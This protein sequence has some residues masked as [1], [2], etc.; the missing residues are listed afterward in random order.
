V[1]VAP[2]APKRDVVEE[3]EEDV[4]AGERCEQVIEHEGPFK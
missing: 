2:A 3:I 1:T 4:L